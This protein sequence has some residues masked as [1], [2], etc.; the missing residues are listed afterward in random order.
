MIPSKLGWIVMEIISPIAL[1][2]F[3]IKGNIVQTP[4]SIIFISC[5]VLHYFNRSIIYPLRQNNPAKMPLL[6]AL[7]AFLFNIVNGYI[8]GTYLGSIQEYSIDYMSNWNFILGLCLFI[9]GAYIN[10]KSDNILLS[11]RSHGWARDLER[12]FKLNLE[13]WP[14]ILNL[15]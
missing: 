6:I 15:L 13:I 8:N 3:I 9:L 4:T 12:S 5:W 1:L 2:Y 7:L 10:I 11:L 14:I